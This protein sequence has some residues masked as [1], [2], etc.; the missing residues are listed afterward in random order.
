MVKVIVVYLIIGHLQFT[1]C[2]QWS[3]HT[4]IGDCSG[5]DDDD[6]NNMHNSSGKMA[7]AYK[8]NTE[9]IF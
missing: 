2:L 7:V 6:D 4:V 5:D 3:L 9:P 8:Y 1:R